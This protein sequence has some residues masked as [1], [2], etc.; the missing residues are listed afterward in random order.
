MCDA[1]DDDKARKSVG[2]GGVGEEGVASGDDF[3]VSVF[4]FVLTLISERSGGGFRDSRK[5]RR[6]NAEACSFVASLYCT[7]LSIRPGLNSAGSS[8]SI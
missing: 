1:K 3:S 2:R 6:Y 7:F 4:V 8:L 5:N